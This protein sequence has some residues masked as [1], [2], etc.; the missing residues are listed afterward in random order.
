MAS[1]E[2]QLPSLPEGL[3]AEIERIARAQD[4]SVGEVL[5]EA[6]DRYIKDQQWQA[7]KEYGRMRSSEL[8]LTE[9]DVPGMISG[10]R[11][12]RNRVRGR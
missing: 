8:G 1:G 7:V 12:G 4:R 11:S 2:T 9:A 5:A 10:Y 6:V 3:M